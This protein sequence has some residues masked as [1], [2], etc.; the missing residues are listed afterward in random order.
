MCISRRSSL[1]VV[2][3]FDDPRIMQHV[4]AADEGYE[5]YLV[6]LVTHVY[7]GIACV[8]VLRCYGSCCVG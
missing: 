1:A 7:H 6:L 2:A 3:E 4:A 8:T 5:G